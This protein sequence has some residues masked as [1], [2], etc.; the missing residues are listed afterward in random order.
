MWATIMTESSMINGCQD[1]GMD[2]SYDVQQRL[3]LLHWS[4]SS[5]AS[6]SRRRRAATTVAI[7]SAILFAAATR[8]AFTVAAFTAALAATPFVVIVALVLIILQNADDLWAALLSKLCFFSF[9]YFECV[10]R[11]E[12]CLLDVRCVGGSLDLLG[13]PAHCRSNLQRQVFVVH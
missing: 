1:L 9:M 13:V 7:I 10:R 6:G 2:L 11:P 12:F 5:G 3:H 8:A 4:C